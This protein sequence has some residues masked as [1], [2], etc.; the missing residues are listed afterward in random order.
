[1]ISFD[2]VGGFSLLG[3]F[4]MNFDYF[5]FNVDQNTRTE[6]AGSRLTREGLGH[7]MSWLVISL[8]EKINHVGIFEGTS[9]Q[10]GDF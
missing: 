5:R 10:Y 1:M 2:E 7:Y 8:L 4:K 9:V 3:I 6:R